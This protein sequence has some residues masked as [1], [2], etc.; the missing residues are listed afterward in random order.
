MFFLSLLEH[1]IR[2]PA[3]TLN[4]RLDIAIFQELQKLFVDKINF[5][6][7]MFRPFIGEVLV[8]KL[9]KSDKS[10][11]YLSLGFFDDIHVPEH[12]LQ[13]PSTFDEKE[14][15]WKWDYDGAELFLDLDEEVRF[16]VTQL[17][18]P[19]IPLEQ[20][21]D[22]KPFAPMEIIGDING[23]GLGLVSWWADDGDAEA[24]EDADN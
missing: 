20:E 9:K 18:Y 14:N 15:V 7:I 13:Q 23:S 3:Q 12:H 16:R 1:T 11:I 10:G 19:P 2:I 21:N 8:G 17:K 5:R 22:A 6:L 24:E 4:I